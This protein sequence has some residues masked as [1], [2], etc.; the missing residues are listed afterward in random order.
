MLVF[1]PTKDENDELAG[2]DI[3]AFVGNG[4]AGKV[5]ADGFDDFG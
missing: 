1:T 5:I 2:V 4:G 3:E